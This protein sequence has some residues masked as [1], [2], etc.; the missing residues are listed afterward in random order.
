MDL[1]YFN[2]LNQYN[3]PLY[4]LNKPTSP[5]TCTQT[6]E[7]EL[8]LDL[9]QRRVHLPSRIYYLLIPLGRCLYPE[10]ISEF[11]NTSTSDFKITVAS[12]S[13]SV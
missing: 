6:D 13:S 4:N 8:T 3:S 5:G 10:I 12:S 2:I 9:C 7:L 11:L 1:Q